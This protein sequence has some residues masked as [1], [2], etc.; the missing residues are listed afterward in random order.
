[1]EE[2][3]LQGFTVRRQNLLQTGKQK[4]VF[5]DIIRADQSHRFSPPFRIEPGTILNKEPVS[6][7]KGFSEF[8]LGE[9]AE[10]VGRATLSK[11]SRGTFKNF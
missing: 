8:S 4:L 9:I 3:P 6:K 10:K 2:L 1:L 7:N 11:G 5:I